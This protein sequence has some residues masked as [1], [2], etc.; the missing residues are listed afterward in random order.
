MKLILEWSNQERTIRSSFLRSKFG[1]FFDARSEL[2][3]NDFSSKNAAQLSDA[4][5]TSHVATDDALCV[6]PLFPFT[7]R[8]LLL[9]VYCSVV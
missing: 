1:S 4:A 6:L 7:L 8:A 2:Q 9:V 3:K 5:F